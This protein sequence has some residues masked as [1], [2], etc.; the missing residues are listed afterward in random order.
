MSPSL[1]RPNESNKGSIAQ[2]KS[3][4]LLARRICMVCLKSSSQTHS[5]RKKTTM[6]FSLRWVQHLSQSI[7]W[8][9]HKTQTRRDQCCRVELQEVLWDRQSMSQLRANQWMQL[10]I[11]ETVR[12]GMNVIVQS[13]KKA[14]PAMM[15]SSS[16]AISSHQ[17]SNKQR[18]LFFRKSFPLRVRLQQR[19]WDHSW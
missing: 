4:L 13:R 19:N 10:C 8:R 3:S 9:Q 16:K 15:N 5:R 11:W 18:V 2:S 14:Q 12:Y 1:E 6:T 7:A 17:V